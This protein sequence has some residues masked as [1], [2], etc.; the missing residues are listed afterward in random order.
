MDFPTALRPIRVEYL[1]PAAIEPGSNTLYGLQKGIT[2]EAVIVKDTSRFSQ[3][4]ALMDT[5]ANALKTYAETEKLLINTTR[6][7][8]LT[9]TGRD[10][11]VGEHGRLYVITGPSNRLYYLFFTRGTVFE[12]LS[13][14][15]PLPS[16]SDESLILSLAGKADRKITAPVPA[17]TVPAATVPAAAEGTAAPKD[18]GPSPRSFM[19]SATA[20]QR[21]PT[22]I[23]V[24]FQGGRDAQE[25]T[26]LAI[27]VSDDNGTGQTFT[28][29]RPSPGL[30]VPTGGYHTFTGTF[31]GRNRVTATATFLDGS[32]SVVLDTIV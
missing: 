29:T 14:E 24:T 7:P 13:L 20:E 21:D 4:A 18:A 9:A 25:L 32:A 22:H 23:T 15:V 1:D 2:F 6:I 30:P 31:S 5:P 28:L 27:E 12:I 16:P 19:I 8:S 3:I 10:V 11:P 17:A 26:S